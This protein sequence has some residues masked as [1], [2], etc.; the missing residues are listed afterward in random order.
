MDVTSASP[1]GCRG[2]AGRA[3][4]LALARHPQLKGWRVYLCGN[5]AMVK[6]TKRK[7]YLAGA[8]LHDIHSDPFEFSHHSDPAETGATV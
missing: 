2:A 8:A 1:G 5:T 7:A 4:D 6:A 3:A